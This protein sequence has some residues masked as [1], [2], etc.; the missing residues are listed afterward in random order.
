MSQRHL[1]GDLVQTLNGLVREGAI[2]GFR[3]NLF[4]GAEEEVI[5]TVTAPEADELD[6]TWQR[7]T[8]ALAPLPFDVVVR[9]DLP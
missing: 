1:R 5:V 2:T 3:T 8:Q 6:T 9:V 7:V 4:D